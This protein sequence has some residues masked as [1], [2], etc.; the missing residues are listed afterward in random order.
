MTRTVPSHKWNICS[1]FL[2]SF[3]TVTSI[4]LSSESP[5]RTWQSLDC[6]AMNWVQ[7]SSN[8]ENHCSVMRIGTVL[9]DCATYPLPIWLLN[10]DMNLFTA[11]MPSPFPI[12]YWL[13]P[14]HPIEVASLRLTYSWITLFSWNLVCLFVKFLVLTCLFPIFHLLYKDQVPLV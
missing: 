6:I 12:K 10:A 13:F 11:M 2:I 8:Y 1:S 9:M 3:A 7:L 4:S 14:T 5:W